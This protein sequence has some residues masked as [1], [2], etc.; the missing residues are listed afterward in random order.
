MQ[1][2][3]FFNK[4]SRPKKAVVITAILVALYTILGFLVAPPILKFILIS[5]ISEQT[6]RNASVNKIKVNPFAFSVTLQG[7]EMN[8]PDGGQFV[9]FDEFYVNFQLSSIFRQ[10]FTFAEIRL[11]GP[12]GRVKVLPD[13]KVNFSDI[14]A[15]LNRTEPG[16]VPEQDSQTTGLPPVIIYKLQIIQG[17]LAFNDLSRPTPFETSLF[18]LQLT[19]DNFST[20]KDKE[21][22]YAF[23]AT[24]GKGGILAW[25][26]NFSIN[27]LSSQGRFELSGIR[28]RTLWEYI[29]DQVKFEVNGGSIDLAGVYKADLSGE[30]IQVELIDGGIELAGFKLMEKGSDEELMSVPSF[31]VKGV[32]VNLGEKQAVVASVRSDDG[33]FVVVRTRDGTYNYQKLVPAQLLESEDRKSTD[34]GVQPVDEER[35]W[36]VR[37]N[38]VIIENYG[39]RLEDHLFEK[40]MVATLDSINANLKNLSNEKESEA[41]VN[42]ALSIDKKGRVEV[43]GVASM[44]PVSA[45]LHLRAAKTPMRA[46]QAYLEALTQVQLASAATNLDAQLKYNRLGSNGPLMRL[47]GNVRIDDIKLVERSSS[48]DL[49]RCES[50][51]ANGLAFDINPSKLSV[52]EIVLRQPYAKVIIFPDATVNLAKAFAVKESEG[53]KEELLLFEKIV[54]GFELQLEQQMPISMDKVRIENGSADFAD[55]FIKPNFAADIKGLNGTVNGLSSK[56]QTRASVLLGGKVDK[57]APVKITGQ[58]NPLSPDVY[59]D[60]A[61]SFKNMNLTRLSPYSGRFAGYLIEK[62]K[63]SV[64]L[65]YKV[66]GETLVGENE[67]FLNQ[68]TLGERVDSPDATSLPVGLAIALLKDRDGNIELDVPVSGNLKDPEFNIGGVVAKAVGQVITKIV[69]SPFALLASLVG[70]GEG[71]EL[72]FIE[73]DFG[74]ATLGNTQAEKLDR[75]AKA[76]QERPALTLEIEGAADKQSDRMALAEAELLNQLKVGRFEE[77]GKAG[78]TVPPSAEE[79][80]LSYDDYARL[81]TQQYMDKFGKD[82]KTIFLGELGSAAEKQQVIDQEVIISAAKEKLVESMPVDEA[83]L[84]QLAQERAMQIRDHLLQEGK[85]PADR[86]FLRGVEIIDATDGETVRTHLTLSGT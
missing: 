35:A 15:S 84:K 43:E 69:T 14:L 24:L 31:S 61:L 45:D 66:S 38:E 67:I 1:I 10:A 48:E 34:A 23:T 74:K 6:G 9:A 29:Q 39:A 4:L 13:G 18:P 28:L 37:V 27:P 81:I 73:F 25:Q 3:A 86:L 32:N 59:V 54:R 56:S 79:M 19:L 20:L 65:K 55:L 36:A 82:P 70:G 85:I 51:A 58:M 63:M 52:S 60:L 46:L 47:T 44:D 50:L 40:P 8:E 68:L 17:R 7:F 26:G 62:G 33:W 12:H 16:P 22:P 30:S 80:T 11:I 72:D 21:S 2:M 64:D 77:L 53:S 57:Q 42:L 5:N 78:K 71:E 76:L 49:A 41:Q 75:L 83:R